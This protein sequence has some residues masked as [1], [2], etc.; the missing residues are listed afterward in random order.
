MYGC[1]L[2]AEFYT[3]NWTEQNSIV[4]NVLW[5]CLSV[6]GDGRRVGGRSFQ[7]HGPETANLR[8]P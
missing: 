4:F 2:S 3:L 7:T 6:P 1:F 8:G 5:N